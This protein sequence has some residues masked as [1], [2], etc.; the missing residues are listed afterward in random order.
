MNHASYNLPQDQLKVWFDDRL[1]EADY[2]EATSYALRFR[3]FPGQKCFCA[4]WSPQAEDFITS[5]SIAIEEDD[6]ADDVESRVE[7][8][9]GH[10]EKA[11]DSSASAQ[12]YLDERANTERRRKNALNAIE[13]EAEKAAHWQDRIASAIRHA[14]Y[15]ERPDVIARRIKGLEADK[16]KMQK[17]AD[18][19]AHWAGVWD[20]PGLTLER[21]QKI[22][23]YDN[24]DTWSALERG[25]ITAE[26][27]CA[28]AQ[29]KHAASLALAARWIVHLDDR[30]LYETAFFKAQG[31]TEEELHPARRKGKAALPLLNIK[32]NVTIRK[33]YGRP[34]EGD[35]LPCREMTKAE[36]AAFPPDM[37]GTSISLCGAFRV[38]QALST[39]PYERFTV[40]LTDAKQ[41]QKPSAETV[42]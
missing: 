5:R 30:L 8:Y 39:R 18:E 28:Q 29:K 27:A 7:R 22:A 2:K 16:R 12:T 4:K 1:S 42:A 36:F 41:D 24:S 13:R 3:W 32:G 6:R 37:K 11:A 38:R 34:H 31:G 40:F 15:K 25:E 9:A 26:Q 23:N 20:K 21:A 35:V 10:A 17:T 14:A 33:M 19:A